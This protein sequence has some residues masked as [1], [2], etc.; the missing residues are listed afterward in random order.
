ML[1]PGF[2]ILGMPSVETFLTRFVYIST[3]PA[4]LFLSEMPCDIHLYEILDASN[5]PENQKIESCNLS[6]LHLVALVKS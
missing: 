4:R 5:D 6:E 2:E 3:R 1:S